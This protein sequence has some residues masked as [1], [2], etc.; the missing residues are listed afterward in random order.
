MSRYESDERNMR[1]ADEGF[2]T[3]DRLTTADMAS[4]IS[5]APQ[6]AQSNQGAPTAAQ[7]V[8]A[9]SNEEGSEPLFAE[10]ESQDFRFR[11]ERIQAGFVDE[12]R[13]AVE[14]ADELVATVIKRLAEV[15]A[16]ERTSLEQEWDRGDD[17]STEDLRIALRR[18]R[19]FF[20][21]LLSV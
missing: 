14:Q 15:F 8:P 20:D 3:T 5:R 6:R 10:D 17:V 13:M 11:W 16:K 12:P 18:Y 9:Q 1:E 19:S 2:D 21:R 4:A 7:A